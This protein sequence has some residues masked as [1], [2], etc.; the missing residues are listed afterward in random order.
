MSLAI[1]ARN[2]G[3]LREAGAAMRRAADT[4][5]GMR[6]RAVER[7][8][9]DRTMAVIDLDLGRFA[10]ARD[11]LLALI[12][13]TGS[14]TER[15]LQWRI[16][17]NVYAEMGD[18]EAT[19]RA[20]Q[21]ALALLRPESREPAALCRQALARGLA[22]TGHASQAVDA[23]DEVI[24]ALIAGGR[25][26]NSTE[27]LRASRYR[28]EFLMRAGRGPEALLALRELRRQ[29][30]ATAASPVERGLVLDLLGEEEAR[31][32]DATAARQAHRAAHAALME[33]LPDGHP[34][35]AR[36]ESLRSAHQ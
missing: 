32:G 2:A 35:L 21:S 33:Q 23:M 1:T 27:V 19:I 36:N 3:Q 13:T 5:E 22:L 25:K 29:H 24:R 18:G 7:A 26:E 8:Q 34:Y 16:L 12:D 17:A 9:L 11:R 31:A 30:E 15:A 10:Q 4:A 20:A 6:L 28:A 14:A